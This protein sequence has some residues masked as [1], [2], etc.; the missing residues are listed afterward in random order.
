MP[1]PRVYEANR[2][3]LRKARHFG[4]S[5]RV[6]FLAPVN[7]INIHL[8]ENFEA[9]TNSE[10]KSMKV[11]NEMINLLGRRKVSVF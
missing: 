11:T 7:F 5:V 1:I 2:L 9:C 3:N 10:N 6:V 4:E 8:S